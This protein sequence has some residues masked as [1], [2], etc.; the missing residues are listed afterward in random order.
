[1]EL[2]LL[3]DLKRIFRFVKNEMELE[4]DEEIIR[5]A[6]ANHIQ[7]LEGVGGRL[8]LT[9]RRLFFK[10]HMFNVKTREI[11]IP[12]EDIIAVETKGSDFISKK[13]EIFLKNGSIEE[14][15]VNHRKRWVEEIEQAIEEKEKASGRRWYIRNKESLTVP[16][17]PLTHPLKLLVQAILLGVCVSL[18]IYFFLRI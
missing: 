8:L 1:L 11:S 13:L 16:Q 3:L 9:N 14:F 15:I 4:T 6:R 18:L 7:P 12:L 17:K 2:I 10:S 5:K